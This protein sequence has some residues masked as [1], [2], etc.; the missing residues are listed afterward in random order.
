[1]ISGRLGACFTRWQPSNRKENCLKINR[2]FRA[3]DMEGLYKKVIKGY[4]PKVP[5]CYG[6]DLQNVIKAL[7]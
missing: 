6:Q 2:P 3:E 4:Y 7:L 5:A 1:V